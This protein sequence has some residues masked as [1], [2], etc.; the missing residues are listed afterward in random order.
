MLCVDQAR[1]LVLSSGEMFAG[2]L[3]RGSSS[4]D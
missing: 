2:V 3:E 4:G 1:S